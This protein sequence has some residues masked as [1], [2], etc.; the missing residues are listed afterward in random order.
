MH[1][2]IHKKG[3]KRRL[4]YLLSFSVWVLLSLSNQLYGQVHYDSARIS[5][6]Q[7]DSNS[8]ET[9]RNDPDFLYDRHVQKLELSWWDRQLIKLQRFIFGQTDAGET[10]WK[11]MGYGIAI[12]AVLLIVFG[13]LKIGLKGVIGK[14]STSLD[15]GFS[16]IAG[17]IEEVNFEQLIAQALK[18]RAYKRGVRLLY[19]ETLKGLTQNNWI[20]WKPN[21][22]NQQYQHELKGSRLQD[23]FDELTLRYEYIW[24]GD[25]PVD[26][27]G[28][29]RMQQVFKTFQQRVTQNI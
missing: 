6:R 17:D 1:L 21:K 10:F 24:Y 23:A 15:M 16:E 28:F 9:Y 7:F 5:V 18:A 25:F 13:L 22:T 19:L 2:N 12:M 26:L 20:S 3:K 8:L 11:V 29:E 14:S 27:A 4:S